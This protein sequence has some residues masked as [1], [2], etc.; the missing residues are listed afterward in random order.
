MVAVVDEHVNGTGQFL[1]R[2]DGIAVQYFAEFG[3]S[4]SEEIAGATSS[5]LVDVIGN[6][7]IL[8]R[9]N[10]ETSE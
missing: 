8:Y 1:Q 2:L 4:P 9:E 10:A 3:I 6:V 5:T 7:A